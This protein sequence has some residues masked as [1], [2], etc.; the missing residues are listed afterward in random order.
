M[1]SAVHITTP[2][3]PFSPG[4]F[5]V[6]SRVPSGSVV[7]SPY[8]WWATSRM[9]CS[10]LICT[11]ERPLPSFTTTEANSP[12]LSVTSVTVSPSGSRARKVGISSV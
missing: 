4:F 1:L 5:E 10:T 6:A 9:S 11:R 12:P 2:E 3:P 7:A 8:S